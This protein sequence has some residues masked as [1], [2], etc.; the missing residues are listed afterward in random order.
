M[1]KVFGILILGFAFHISV[2]AQPSITITDASPAVN[3]QNFC[4]DVNVRDFSVLLSMQFTV[5][6]N[7]EVISFNQITNING[8]VDNLGLPQSFDLTNTADGSFVFDWATLGPDCSELG[9][10]PVT[11]EPNNIDQVL[12]SICFDAVGS[13]GDNTDINILGPPVVT[14]QFTPTPRCNNIGAFTDDGFVSL[15]VRPLTIYASDENVNEGD[16]VCVDFSVTGFD[17]L[18]SVQFSVEWDHTNLE[19]VEVQI[20][21]IPNTSISSFATPDF[22]PEFGDSIM[23]ASWS[24]IVPSGAGITV[25]D[26][27]LFFSVCYN[28]IGECEETTSVNIVSEPTN[29]EVINTVELGTRITLIPESGSVTTNDCIPSG[30]QLTADCPGPLDLNENGCVAIRAGNNFNSISDLEFLISFNENILEYTGIN[31]GALPNFNEANNINTT[32]AAG[33]IIGVE[34]ET[35]PLPSQTLGNN[36]VLFEICFDAVGLGGNSPIII[37]PTPAVAREN[38]GP[39]LGINPTNCII[40]VNQPNGVTLTI[41]D[42]NVP[43]NGETCLD[44]TVSNFVDIES[45]QFSLNWDETQIEF[46]SI[47]S[48]TLPGADNSNFVTALAP[49]G[50]LTFEWDAA[51]AVTVGDGDVIMTLCFRAIGDPNTCS[52]IDVVDFPLARVATSSSSNGE[53]IGIVGQVGDFCILNPDGFFLVLPEGEGVRGDTLCFPVR[54]TDFDDITVANFDIL[55]NPTLLEFIELGTTFDIPGLNGANVNT[56]NADIGFINIDWADPSGVTVPDSTVMLELCFALNDDR[57]YECS[58]LRTNNSTVEV[59]AGVGSLIPVD[60]EICI[61][62]KLELISADIQGVTCPGD[63]D[64][65]IEL[66]VEGGLGPLVFN[67]Q[68]TPPQFTNRATNLPGGPIEV[69]V[70][71]IE[72]S[73]LI[74]TFSFVIP[75][76]IGPIVGFPSDTL[77]ASCDPPLTLATGISS[78]EEGTLVCRWTTLGGTLLATGNSALLPGEGEYRFICEVEE[79]GCTAVDT[80]TVLPPVLPIADAGQDVPL[81]CDSGPQNLDGSGSETIG[82]SYLWTV[83][84]GGIVINPGEETMINP[85]FTSTEGGTIELTVTINATGCSATDTVAVLSQGGFPVANAGTD[86]VLGCTGSVTLD[87][88]NSFNE[89]PVT[90]QWVDADD[91]SVLADDITFETDQVGT[92]VLVVT[93]TL[94]NCVTTD[95]IEVTQ[96]EDFPIVSITQDT[97]FNCTIDTVALSLQIDNADLFEFLWSS[98]DGEFTFGTNNTQTPQIL[99]PGATYEVVVTNV[100]NNCASTASISVPI[101]TITPTVVPAFADT[102]LV[103]C[104]FPQYTVNGMGS[105]MG[106]EFTYIWSNEFGVIPTPGDSLDVSDPGTYFLEIQN[107]V[108]GCSAIDSFVVDTTFLAPVLSAIE[109]PFLSC[110]TDSII[111]IATPEIG[112]VDADSITVAWTGGA[113]ENADQLEAIVRQAGTYQVEVTV[114]ASGCSETV[115]VT[116]MQDDEV[117]VAAITAAMTE[118]TCADDLLML[119]ASSASSNGERYVYEWI[120][121]EGGQLAFGAENDPNVDIF[122]P[123]TYELVV[124]DTLFDCSASDIITIT[125][126]IVEPMVSIGSDTSL[127]CLYTA[128]Q[129]NTAL[130]SVGP[131]YTYTWIKDNAPEA[132]SDELNFAVTEPGEYNLIVTDTTNGCTAIDVGFITDLREEL[133]TLMIDQTENLSCIVE[134]TSVSVV[135]SPADNYDYQWFLVDEMGMAQAIM[136]ETDSI[137]TLDAGGMYQIEVIDPISECGATVDVE[138]VQDTITPLAVIQMDMVDS[139]F[140]TCEETTV[141]LSG[142]GSSSGPLFDLKWSQVLPFVQDSLADVI[143]YETSLVGTYALEVTNSVTGC[144]AMDTITVEENYV[145]PELIVNQPDTFFCSSTT[146]DLDATASIIAGD[147]E[148]EWLSFGAGNIISTDLTAQADSA[149]TYQLTVVTNPDI[150]ECLIR[151]TV[152][153]PG[154]FQAPEI[155]AM[156]PDTFTCFTSAIMLD[157]TQ[158]TGN[159][160]LTSNWTTVEGGTITPDDLEASVDAPG[161]YQLILS[162]NP[163]ITAC[164]TVDT[165]EVLANPETPELT[166]APIDTFTCAEEPFVLIDATPSGIGTDNLETIEWLNESGGADPVATGNQF[167]VQALEPGTYSVNISLNSVLGDCSAMTTVTVGQDTIAPTADLAAVEEL[168]CVNDSIALNASASMANSMNN[169]VLTF[170]WEGIQDND[171]AFVDDIKDQAAVEVVEGGNYRLTITDQ[172]NNC[173]TIVVNEVN[174]NTVPPTPSVLDADPIGCDMEPVSLDGTASGNTAD[175]A[176]ILWTGV[177]VDDPSPNNALVTTV[178]QAGTYELLIRRADNG[179]DSTIT[180]IVEDDMNFP[181]AEAGAPSQTIGCGPDGTLLDGSSSS[182]G[183]NITYQWTVLDGAANLTEP[184]QASTGIDA[185]GTFVL[186]VTDTDNACEAT[187]TV[188]VTLEVDLPLADLGPDEGICEDST[189]LFADIPAGAT[190]AWRAESGGAFIEDAM[191]SSTFVSNLS[192]GANVFTF[193]LSAE[194]CENYSTDTLIVTLAESPTASSDLVTLAEEQEVA[195]FNVTDNDVVVGGGFNL[196]LISQ[197]SFGELD[198]NET[199][200][201]SIYTI[202]LGQ[203]GDT[204]FTYELCSDICPNLC[205]E[206]LVQIEVPEAEIEFNIPNGITMNDDGVNDTFVFDQ[207]LLNPDQFPDNEMIIFN[208]WGDIVFQAKPYL[209]DFMGIS[210]DGNELPEGTYYYI[211]RLNIAEGE[212]IRGD[213]TIV[214]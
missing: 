136:G 175:F 37:P 71:D 182:Q 98:T 105:S 211:L 159:G 11:I 209:N 210:D 140:I 146:V 139:V 138:V 120:P 95:T 153:I 178:A 118:L 54:V 113:I 108:N 186:L 124:T 51:S 79:T 106:D 90:Y 58:P 16:Q 86:R 114:N 43:L 190:G 62:D 199:T 77:I 191:S 72:N 46:V 127:T 202:K 193:T 42:A 170:S 214:K 1:K 188:V 168:T 68:T 134:E 132:V 27:T 197:P 49:A 73:D 78:V 6:W 115:E 76:G 207:L 133:P 93:N 161:T 143:Q 165:F 164:T 45:F 194:G 26:S 201:Q 173:E 158:S 25:P 70:F 117:P 154:D 185:A 75:S 206:G 125:Q 65:S 205:D 119:D 48:V 94:T 3:E 89:F 195:E 17:D 52:P 167:V 81:S 169:G 213:L 130:T 41:P 180:V 13:Y 100:L 128:H 87:G 50:A 28:V 18:T 152:E 29:F 7:P 14:R 116:V 21:D 112:S 151:T 107:T 20:G 198:F 35:G 200:G 55:F 110:S 123:G 157:A 30:L 121:T 104:A 189:M 24:F 141:T 166:F 171:D 19:F 91:D 57:P 181:T 32:N 99:T 56:D 67:W 36:A 9:S 183:D 137:I 97:V 96:N 204:E 12:F 59:L 174:E 47:Q 8:D 82:V 203:F 177:D 69:I 44:F 184:T 2:I 142:N 122:A 135:P 66:E 22:I 101:D 60:G 5:E 212:I 156:E 10:N 148:A 84:T 64:G 33:G 103:N 23:T 172:G 88:S 155:V 34:W 40:E 192:P 129:F 162:T 15:G 53:N 92:Y 4:V 109:P 176:E 147:F 160:T 149:G 85:G 131:Q 31:T 74:D 111:L 208:R 80:L 145:V 150:P 144:T 179:C 163:I 102:L 126:N 83:L 38:D 187:D 39:N 61:L 196:R 63:T